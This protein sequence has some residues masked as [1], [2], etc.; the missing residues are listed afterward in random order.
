MGAT[1]EGIRAVKPLEAQGSNCNRTLLCSFAQASACAEAGEDLIS[2]FVGRIM[3]WD[4][5][6][7]QVQGIEPADDPEVIS[8]R[9]IVDY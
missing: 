7:M 8:V 3:E 4:K 9:R 2:T 6:D 5:A 1:W